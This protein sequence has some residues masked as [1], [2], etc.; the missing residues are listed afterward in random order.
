MSFTSPQFWL[1]VIF[2]F[3][4]TSVFSA[5]HL[6]RSVLLAAS[7]IFY[8][9]GDGAI[10]WILLVSS[11]IDYIAGFSVAPENR[12]AKRRLALALSLIGN[13]GFLFFFKYLH[14]V[15]ADVLPLIGISGVGK[16]IGI[17]PLPLGISFYTFQSMSY[18]IDIYR[19]KLKPCRSYWDFLLFV[20]FFPQLIAGPIERA[21]HLLPQ[22]LKARRTDLDGLRLAMVYIAM[23]FF[24][25][26][27]IADSIGTTAQLILT[28]TNARPLEWYLG[29]WTL[30][31]QVYFD[32]SAYSDFALG[33]GLIFG[34]Q[35]SENFRPVWFATNPLTFWERWNITTGRW[36]RDYFL[37][38]IGG[39]G[40]SRL[41]AAR[42]MILMFG[43]VG[44][45][46]GA[47][48]NWIIWGLMHGV[49]VAVYR[50]IKKHRPQFVRV[51][52]AVFG[53]LFIQLVL[54]PVSGLLHFASDKSF[55]ENTARSLEHS[56]LDLSGIRTYLPHIMGYVIPGIGLDIL[57]EKFDFRKDMS[58]EA[59]FGMSA[60][61]L[62]FAFFLTKGVR[63]L[64]FVYFS[65]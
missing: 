37:V 32:F 31:M 9:S 13:L 29:G 50:D 65:F 63:H 53:F 57:R 8:S 11:G 46:H 27:Y 26:L 40:S 16:D 49:I 14:F 4:L 33:L 6:Y 35:I 43:L 30:A 24:K 1:L 20:T 41:T 52:P 45:W 44:L 22:I 54:L 5:G 7:L 21:T 36:F 3:G 48:W 59:Q 19:G 61:L 56:L 38:P 51:V 60:L 25:K 10:L 34:V 64:S 17:W 2:T 55:L 47:S 62:G 12:L 28:D 58:I 18:T 42:N 15:T 39:N 23:G